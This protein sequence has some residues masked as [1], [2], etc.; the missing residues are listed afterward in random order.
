M[1]RPLSVVSIDP[2]SDPLWE[3]LLDA[4][5]AGLFH[6]PQWMRSVC[7]A[8]NFDPRAHV[9]V[10]AAGIPQGGVAFC[11]LRDPLGCRMVSFPFS[12]VGGPLLRSPEAW[13]LLLERLAEQRLPTTFRCFQGSLPGSDP[14]FVIIKRARWHTLPLSEP[15]S[16]L[17]HQFGD[18][19]RRAISKA[20]RAGVT[21]KPLEGAAGLAAFVQLHMRLRKRKYRLLAQP[22][23]F[24]ESI[25]NRFSAA[26]MWHPL[27]A[28]LGDRLL[29]A[30][31][32]LRW[33]DTLYYKFNASDPDGLACRPNNLLIW[34]GI[35]LAQSL[36]C[37]ALDLGP[38]DDNQP[39]LI[40]FKREFGATERELQFLQWTPPGCPPPVDNPMRGVL[41]EL[42]QLFTV[43]G[44]PDE[45]TSAAGALLYKFFA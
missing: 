25:A 2:A 7:D 3:A 41:G 22:A 19:T 37:R 36:G 14:G 45:V 16:A 33:G 39:G 20:E 12:D 29:A 21:I 24:F 28:S 5:G 34:G 17:R 1:M 13:A 30:T 35:Q 6:S 40:R 4:P 9:V 15:A 27:G 18:T 8:Y 10:D 26:G 32:Y 43:P 42:S 44:V 31:I 23:A 38:S 11:E